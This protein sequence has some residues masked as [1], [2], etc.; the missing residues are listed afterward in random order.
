MQK[1]NMPTVSVPVSVIRGL[2]TTHPEL[3]IYDNENSDREVFVN[4][5]W[6]DSA[7]LK[8]FAE[9]L[10]VNPSDVE[11]RFVHLT[12]KLSS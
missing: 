12:A 1:T 10:R 7:S 8:S 2:S 9:L 4:T 6:L 5:E 3:V 11:F